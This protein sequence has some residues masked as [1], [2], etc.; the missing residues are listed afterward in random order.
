MTSCFDGV[1][2]V[3]FG[4]GFD[5]GEFGDLAGCVIIL[6]LVVVSPF[7]LLHDGGDS[8]L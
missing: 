7:L 6:F 2:E 4:E 1:G 8:A 5:E 3:E